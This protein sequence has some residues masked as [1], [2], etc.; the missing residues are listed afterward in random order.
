MK[1][2]VLHF[3]ICV[4]VESGSPQRLSYKMT[5]WPTG[6]IQI[7]QG[8][9][10]VKDKSVCITHVILVCTKCHPCIFGRR[11]NQFFSKLSKNANNF[12]I[13]KLF[14]KKVKCVHKFKMIFDLQHIRMIF[15][16]IKCFVDIYLY[17]FLILLILC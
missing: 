4:D 6:T 1:G 10:F 14:M 3:L 13:Y 5:K 17:S 7:L 15:I 8:H 11:T 9:Q 12:Q 2:D 16:Y